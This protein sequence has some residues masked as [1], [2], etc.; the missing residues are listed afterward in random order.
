MRHSQVDIIPSFVRTIGCAA[1]RVLVQL[2]LLVFTLVVCLLLSGGLYICLHLLLSVLVIYFHLVLTE[3]FV[4]PSVFF[5]NLYLQAKIFLNS[6]FWTNFRAKCNLT[7]H[8]MLLWFY[9]FSSSLLTINR[10][11]INYSLLYTISYTYSVT[12]IFNSNIL[13]DISCLTLS[14]YSKVSRSASSSRSTHLTHHFPLPHP[15]IRCLLVHSATVSVVS[16]N[17]TLLNRQLLVHHF[18]SHLPPSRL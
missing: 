10:W 17:S 13:F 15:S 9:T 14:C 5:Y 8:L 18:Y 2:K 1:V 7:Y 3:Y 16:V 12:I 4:F 11:P 6:I